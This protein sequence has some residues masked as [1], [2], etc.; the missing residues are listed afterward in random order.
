MS[1]SHYNGPEKGE[2]AGIEEN[3]YIKWMYYLVLASSVFS[4]ISS[5]LVFVSVG[6]PLGGVFGLAGVLGL[7]M[8]G[9]A[10]FG[11]RD[12]ITALNSSHS[13]FVLVVALAFFVGGILI[14]S[15]FAKLGVLLFIVNLLVSASGFV[16]L[17]SGYKLWKEGVVASQAS[18][19]AK[20]LSVLG[21]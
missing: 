5:I 19:K 12:F 3:K 17:F 4:V 10:F 20:V 21:K 6:L 14:A 1:D 7:V 8:A 2:I 18:V 11:F 13:A 16:V 9:V 15:I